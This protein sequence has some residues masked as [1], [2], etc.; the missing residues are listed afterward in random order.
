MSD[1][2]VTNQVDDS[3][4]FAAAFSRLANTNGTLTIETLLMA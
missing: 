4:L 2:A 3:G 1:V